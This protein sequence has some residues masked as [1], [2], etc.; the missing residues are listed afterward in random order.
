M[1][2]PFGRQTLEIPGWLPEPLAN[3]SGDHWR[4]REKKLRNAQTVV[5][6]AAKQAG[7]APVTGRAKLTI[8]LV[9]GVQRRR[10]TDNLYA[11]VKGCVDG[12]KPHPA[13]TAQFKQALVIDSPGWITDDDT[14]HLELVVRA[15]VS[16]V[17]M[18][19]RMTL[20]PAA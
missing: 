13:A 6:V 11:R 15:E 19:T 1:T 17:W 8:T 4:K 3:V 10:D 5:W 9:F 14:E 12:L 16:K 7:W 2:L 18:G 20:E